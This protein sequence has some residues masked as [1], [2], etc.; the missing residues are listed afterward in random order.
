MMGSLCGKS[1]DARRNPQAR[2]EEFIAFPVLNS[3][4]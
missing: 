2:A 1:P 4:Y 3:Y